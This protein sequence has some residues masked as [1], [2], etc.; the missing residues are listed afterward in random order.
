M[1]ENPF[2]EIV[3]IALAIVSNRVL[4]AHHY[5]ELTFFKIG[6]RLCQLLQQ[7]LVLLQVFGVKSVGESA[8]ALG[9]HPVCFCVLAVFLPQAIPAHGC[10]Q[11]QGLGT[12][13]AIARQGLGAQFFAEAG[14]VLELILR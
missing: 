5:V 1:Q 8:V 10:A 14:R 13:P 11:L 2:G 6:L 9:Q 12:L 7:R 4:F 3:W